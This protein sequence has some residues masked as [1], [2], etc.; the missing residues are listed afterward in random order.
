MSNPNWRHDTPEIIPETPLSLEE[1]T[2][3]V[4]GC[5]SYPTVYR[6]ALRIGLQASLFNGPGESGLATFLTIYEPLF[7]E[8][9][10]V[11]KNMFLTHANGLFNS[12]FFIVSFQSRNRARG[13]NNNRDNF[14]S[15]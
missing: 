1:L 7:N 5:V 12:G 6:S 9:N 15:D 2:T 3:L 4:C 13:F 8:H 14:I 11:T 10:L